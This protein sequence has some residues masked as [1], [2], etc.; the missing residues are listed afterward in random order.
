MN[1]YPDYLKS[2]PQ[3]EYEAHIQ[4]LQREM[5]ETGLDLLL[6]SSPEN[7]FYT[8]GYR[9]W[10]LSSLFRPVLVFVPRKGEPAIYL[11]ILEKSTVENVSW[12]PNIYVSGTKSRNLGPLNAEGPADALRKFRAAL[13]YETKKIGLEA[14]DGQHYFWSLSTLKEL[15]D[16]F[17]DCSFTDGTRAIQRARMIKT[18][19]EIGKIQTAGYVTERA[20]EETFRTIRPGITTE[21]EIA[22]GIASRMT[23]GGVDKISYLTVNSGR[24][25]YHTF[26]SYATD[27]IVDFGDLVLVDISGHIDGY[28]SDLTRVMYL[29]KEPGEDYREMAETARECVHA[30]LRVCRPGARIS[31]V[32]REIEGYLRRSKYGKQVVHSSGH[33]I[34]LNVTEYPNI[35]DD[36]DEIIRPGMVLALENGVYPYELERGAGTIWISFRME[37]EALVTEEGGQWLS[38]P[39]KALYTLDSI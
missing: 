17:S 5:E 26:N 18:S 31:D 20:I 4:K 21:K 33:S 11:R 10:Y 13:D 8:T 22:R 12:C 25:K 27:R 23:A 34:G 14:G 29:G 3:A 37:D 38:G 15:T 28:A 6:L 9:S 19:W 39:G 2:F 35:S 30:G 1:E 32:S 16:S 24:D 36:C 7:I